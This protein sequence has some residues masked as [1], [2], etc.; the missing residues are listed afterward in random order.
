MDGHYTYREGVYKGHTGTILQ[1]LC[2]GDH[3]LS[4]GSDGILLLWKIGEFDDPQV[5]SYCNH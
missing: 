3:L 2:L 5:P 4:L 1:L